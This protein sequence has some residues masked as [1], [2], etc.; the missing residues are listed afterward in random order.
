M[1][2]VL[3]FF[4]YTLLIII[5]LSCPS[6]VQNKNIYNLPD[7]MVIVTDVDGPIKLF[8][9]NYYVTN[10]FTKQQVKALRESTNY[11]EKESNGIVKINIVPEWKE[12]VPF[13][14]DYYRYYSKK[15]VWLFDSNTKT[16]KELYNKFESFIGLSYGNYIVIINVD[17]SIGIDDM[18]LTIV[19]SHELGHQFGMEHINCKYEALMNNDCNYGNITKWDMLL[20]CSLYD[21][22]NKVIPLLQNPNITL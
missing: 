4:V 14:H 3:S 15:T 22:K 10:Q 12:P 11:W 1:L 13:D 16:A 5:S 8:P 21:C 20:F 7:D 9:V 18:K 2:K 19:F 6:C 17:P